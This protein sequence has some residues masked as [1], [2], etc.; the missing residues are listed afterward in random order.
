MIHIYLKFKSW[1][2]FFFLFFG[3]SC[4]GV[5]ERKRAVL[6]FYSLEF[7]TR[8]LVDCFSL[9]FEWQQ[10]SSSLQDSS[11]YFCQSQQ[12]CSLNS[13]HL[14]SYIQVLQSLYQSFGDCTKNIQFPSKVHV[15]I[16]LFAY[17]QF[18][19][20]VSRDSQVPRTAH[21]LYVLSWMTNELSI[22]STFIYLWHLNGPQSLPSSAHDI[23]SSQSQ[24]SSTHDR[25]RMH[26]LYVLP[27][28]RR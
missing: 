15:L 18:Y 8:A 1:R 25:W 6:L 23:N 12:C 24:R 9:V 21:S 20:V 11:Q 3:G 4:G 10:V 16:F 17:P 5:E 26:S 22:V 27:R 14:S 7:F 28:I 2:R 13:L 19:S